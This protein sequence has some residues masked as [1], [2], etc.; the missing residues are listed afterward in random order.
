[1]LEAVKNHPRNAALLTQCAE[2]LLL[3]HE[4][5]QSLAFWRQAQAGATPRARAA[6]VLC[7]LL[8]GDCQHHFTPAEEPALSREAVQWYRRFIQMGAH[9]VIRD[10]DG[11]METIRL[12]LPSFVRVCEAAHRQARQVAA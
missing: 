9:D 12:S 2:A 10:L 3:S 4:P 5:A 6:L 8:T 7:E 1:M 11:R